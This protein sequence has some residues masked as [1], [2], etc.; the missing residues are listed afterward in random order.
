MNELG[1]KFYLKTRIFNINKLNN[2]CEILFFMHSIKFCSHVNVNYF[3]YMLVC[4][5]LELTCSNYWRWHR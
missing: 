5:A 3:L 2:I 4:P 1:L